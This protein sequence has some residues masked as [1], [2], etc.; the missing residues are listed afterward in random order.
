MPRIRAFPAQDLR[1]LFEMASDHP[2][3]QI[4]HRA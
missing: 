2:I 4:R 1:R 3:Q